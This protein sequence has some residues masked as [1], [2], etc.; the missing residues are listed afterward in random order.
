MKLFG[1]FIIVA[2]LFASTNCSYKLDDS[3]PPSD[4]IPKDTF[5]MLMYDVMILESYYKVQEIPL[6]MYKED[7]P[8]AMKTIFN[9]YELDSARFIR[10][11]DFYSSKQGELYNIYNAIQDSL[12]IK[13]VPYQAE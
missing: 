10:S 3:A 7:L 4:L 8:E 12:T 11:V 9:K 5:I 6:E 13:T 1:Y 2:I